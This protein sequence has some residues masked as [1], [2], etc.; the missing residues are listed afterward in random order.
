M[1]LASFSFSLYMERN[2]EKL[3]LASVD[4]QSKSYTLNKKGKSMLFFPLF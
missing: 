3:K 2:T 4:L 1:I